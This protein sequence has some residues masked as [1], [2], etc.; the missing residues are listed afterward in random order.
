MPNLDT[1]HRLTMVKICEEKSRKWL[2]YL[3]GARALLVDAEAITS[4]PQLAFLAELY[5]YLCCVGPVTTDNVP[6]PLK[7]ELFGHNNLHAGQESLPPRARPFFGLAAPLYGY[8][9]GVNSLAVLRAAGNPSGRLDDHSFRAK[10]GE[11][12][13][14]LQEWNPPDIESTDSHLFETRAVAVAVQWAVLMRL[15]QVS[16]A[17]LP[18]QVFDLVN[19]V[20]QVLSALSVVRPGS[21]SEARLLFPLFIAGVNSMAKANRLTLEFRVN[22]L[23][24]TIGFGNIACAHKLLDETWRRANGGELARWEDLAQEMAPGLILF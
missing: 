17:F 15:R 5:N 20:D 23:N 2:L 6:R 1:V 11:I 21:S 12:E 10:I 24:N 8:L 22:L 18:A 16:S 9:A 19:P 7:D 4:Q 13:V 3:H 14:K